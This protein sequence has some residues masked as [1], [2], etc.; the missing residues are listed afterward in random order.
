MKKTLIALITLAFLGTTMSSRAQDQPGSSGSRNGFRIHSMYFGALLSMPV[1]GLRYLVPASGLGVKFGSQFFFYQPGIANKLVNFGL[2]VQW[3]NVESNIPYFKLDDDDEPPY[4]LAAAANLGPVASIKPTDAMQV[5][6]YYLI[7]TGVRFFPNQ[8]DYIY[9]RYVDPAD[10]HTR[11]SQSV[12]VAFHYKALYTS[13]GMQLLNYAYAY[14]DNG[15][16]FSRRKFS[17]FQF[18]IG[19]CGWQIK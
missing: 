4:S 6:L 8:D 17:T 18:A 9:A 11:F 19:V 13:L 14:T 10:P 1:A 12:G 16:Y 2:N 3:L 5:D 7:G 15:S